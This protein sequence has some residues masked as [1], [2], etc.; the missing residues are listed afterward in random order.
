MPL[1]SKKLR[2]KILRSERR[3]NKGYLL[4]SSERTH[5]SK[6]DAHRNGSPVGIRC[7]RRMLGQ[8]LFDQIC[9]ETGAIAQY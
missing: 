6:C 1:S 5:L 2:A 4:L 3:L 9:T 8:L 7:F